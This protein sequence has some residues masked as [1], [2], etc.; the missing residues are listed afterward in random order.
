MFLFSCAAT[1]IGRSLFWYN[2]FD[3]ALVEGVV[4]RILQ[5]NEHFVRPG[6]KTHQDNWVTT[7]IRPHP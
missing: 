7:G 2:K 4:V 5:F 1:V 3:R 6:G